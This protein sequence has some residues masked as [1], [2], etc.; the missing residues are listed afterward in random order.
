MAAAKSAYI[1]VLEDAVMVGIPK[2][3]DRLVVLIQQISTLHSQG[4]TLKQKPEDITSLQALISLPFTAEVSCW[5]CCYC[6][7]GPYGY[8]SSHV[9]GE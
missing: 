6:Y 4:Q 2:V 9:G 7:D 8:V 3:Y 1:R 5:P